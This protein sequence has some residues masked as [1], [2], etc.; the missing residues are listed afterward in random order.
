MTAR[1]IPAQQWQDTQ[2][3]H[4]TCIILPDG[5][6]KASTLFLAG[7]L[8]RRFHSVQIVLLCTCASRVPCRVHHA[9]L[10]QKRVIDSNPHCWP[11][12]HL[13]GQSSLLQRRTA[14][15][16][17]A[18][19]VASAGA[20]SMAAASSPNE[21]QG[22][23]DLPPTNQVPLLHVSAVRSTSGRCRPRI[24]GRLRDRESMEERHLD[25][26]RKGS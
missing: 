4:G 13:C 2:T 12:S 5:G 3:T 22:R 19:A 8:P 18:T 7:T 11:S 17:S 23:S 26:K 14:P 1:F 24:R 20:V 9:M 16:V 25:D 6:T 21:P 10:V 15:A